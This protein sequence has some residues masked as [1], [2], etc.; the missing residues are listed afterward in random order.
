MLSYRNECRG[1]LLW[2]PCDGAATRARPSMML[3]A[4]I[5]L[6]LALSACGKKGAPEPPDPETDQYPRQYPDPDSL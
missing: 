6:A 3:V 5:L 4:A 1:V 2:S